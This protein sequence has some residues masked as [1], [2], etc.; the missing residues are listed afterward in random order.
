[1]NRIVIPRSPGV[2]FPLLIV[3]VVAQFALSLPAATSSGF[4]PVDPFREWV[5]PYLGFLAVLLFPLFDDDPTMRWTMR[6]M[7]SLA[8]ILCL[9]WVLSNLLSPVPHQTNVVDVLKYG[10][11]LAIPVCSLVWILRPLQSSY[12][13]HRRYQLDST[14][15]VI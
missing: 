14:E 5:A 10:L 4:P 2:S 1:M 8:T 3:A 7:Y 13:H 9:A 15:C 12:Q 11:I 6:V